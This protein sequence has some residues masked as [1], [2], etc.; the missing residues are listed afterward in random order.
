MK[1]ILIILA[2]LITPLNSMS[3]LYSFQWNL[4]FY[5]ETF[6]FMSDKIDPNIYKINQNIT[7]DLLVNNRSYLEKLNQTGFK[8]K[9]KFILVNKETVDLSE[10]DNLFPTEKI[11]IFKIKSY[12]YENLLTHVPIE[13]SLFYVN[14]D[15]ELNH[16]LLVI[17]ILFAFIM[18]F[19]TIVWLIGMFTLSNRLTTTHRIIIMTFSGRII[20]TYLLVGNLI[21]LK[22]SKYRL[23]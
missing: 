4:T 5:I 14:Y 16:I 22:N 11:M 10:E 12:H 17:S 21:L 20:L 6:I 1:W 13:M 23:I 2:Y 18:T 19:L 8:D 15:D 7:Q 9:I 3:I